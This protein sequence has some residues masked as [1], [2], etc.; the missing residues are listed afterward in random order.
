[1]TTNIILS[2]LLFSLRAFALPCFNVYMFL[3]RHAIF[4]YL[5]SNLVPAITFNSR[6]LSFPIFY[7]HFN[8][9]PF[10]SS[11]PSINAPVRLSLCFDRLMYKNIKSSQMA[12]LFSKVYLVG[13]DRRQ[14]SVISFKV[15]LF[16]GFDVV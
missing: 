12:W 1:M 7:L 4:R 10:I 3:F 15:C 16:P 5:H 11:S 8:D 2:L 13:N 6:L 14:S 9:F